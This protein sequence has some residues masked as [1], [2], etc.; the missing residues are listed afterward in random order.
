MN[1]FGSD[2]ARPGKH[3]YTLFY[4][5]L[6]QGVR[7]SSIDVFELGIGSNSPWIASNMG[8]D[9]KPG[10]SLRAWKAYF[11]SARIRAADVD[12]SIL[13]E[14]ERISTFYCDSLDVSSIRSMWSMC[15]I[16]QFDIMID[17]GLHTARSNINF[18]ESSIHKLKQGGVYIIEDVLDQDKSPLQIQVSEWEKR[19]PQFTFHWVE[20]SMEG[21]RD[22]RLLVIQNHT[23]I[24][25]TT[26]VTGYI[27]L[28]LSEPRVATTQMYMTAFAEMLQTSCPMI[29]FVEESIVGRVR[30]MIG[31]RDHTQIVRFTLDDLH[32]P[33]S[34]DEKELPFQL[35]TYRCP[36][37]DTPNYMRV[38]WAKFQ[39][40]QEAALLD[41]FG[42]SHFM[43]VDF[44]AFRHFSTPSQIRSQ[45]RSIS[46][47]PDTAKIRVP[48]GDAKRQDAEKMLMERP[49]W[50]WVGNF[51]SGKKE[52]LLE[53]CKMFRECA[54]KLSGAGKLTWEINLL[55]LLAQENPDRFEEYRPFAPG[56][57]HLSYY[58]NKE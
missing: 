8:L 47:Y 23:Q 35:P 22:N 14:E 31:D 13:F 41:P 33:L 55:A 20:L 24:A 16:N 53:V 57:Q 4:H 38:Q 42:S 19:Y 10:A 40:L 34:F 12:H 11:P 27:P 37:K 7:D 25:P 21:S 51:L 48:T 3:N 9:G 58:W 18:F 36:I 30:D 54:S 5:A 17:D 45:I 6:F 15:D 43:W 52:P 49:F 26:I 28:D 29:V 46:Y 56:L 44:G 50:W 39:W 1:Q 32:F 2:K